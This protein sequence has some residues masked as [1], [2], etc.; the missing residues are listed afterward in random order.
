MNILNNLNRY[1]I[2]DEYKIT[3]YKDKIHIINYIKLKDFS[4]S[5][6]ILK[7][8]QGITTIY[9]NNLVVSR[10]EKEELVI[11]GKIKTIEV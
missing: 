6:V 7:H 10:M 5:K 1:L 8:Q 3:I 2:D 4:D 9:G 11:T